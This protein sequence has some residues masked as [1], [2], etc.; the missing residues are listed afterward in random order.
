MDTA[1]VFKEE[2]LGVSVAVIDGDVEAAIQNQRKLDPSGIYQCHPAG[3]KM[4]AS[5]RGVF[6]LVFRACTSLY[7]PLRL[8]LS[9][10]AVASCRQSAT[11]VFFV[12]I[13]ELCPSILYAWENAESLVTSNV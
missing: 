11:P 3:S 7:A 13:V 1:A 6:G 5:V 12:R 2:T 8:N 9:V 10:H 4:I